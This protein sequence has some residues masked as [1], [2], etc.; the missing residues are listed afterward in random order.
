MIAAFSG[1][2]TLAFVVVSAGVGVRLLWLARRTRALPEL[3]LGIAF[4][5]VGAVGYPL[6]LLSIAPGLPE[7][8]AR[9]LF[10]LA[11]LA[12]GLGSAAVFV[13]TRAVFRPD[14]RWAAMLV[15]A[16]SAVLVVQVAF[17]I[18]RAVNAPPATFAEPD[19]G[20]SVRQGVTALSYGWTALEAL[21]YRALLVR[22]LALGL[23]E[24]VVVNRFLLW[25]IAGAGAFA[26]SSVMS[27]VSL[28]GATP[29]EDPVALLAVGLG[30]FVAAVCA[31]LAF[32]PP[33]A[34][35][36]WLERGTA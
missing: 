19:L 6:G 30:G 2:A 31:W 8:A 29:W 20:F 7:P 17:G 13:F 1:V 18:V 10:A 34:Y 24:A 3:A 32:L 23:A 27:A 21:R 15:A 35:R 33:R 28:S 22:R 11:N 14:A 12:T 4:F 5:A 9:V 25:A 16:S 36:S 26:G